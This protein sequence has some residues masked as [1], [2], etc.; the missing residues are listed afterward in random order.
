MVDLTDFLQQAAASPRGQA[1]GGWTRGKLVAP[2]E[3]LIATREARRLRLAIGDGI[4]QDGENFVAGRYGFPWLQAASGAATTKET[5]AALGLTLAILPLVEISSDALA[6]S[7]NLI[8]PDKEGDLPDFPDLMALIREC[9]LVHGVDEEAMRR[10]YEQASRERV[11]VRRQLI[12]F[13]EPAVPGRDAVIRTEI[14]LGAI[15]GKMLDDGRIDFRERRI[16]VAVKKDEIL[17]VKIPATVGRRGV[18]VRGQEIPTRDGVDIAVKT[19]DLCVFNP[20]DGTIRATGAGILSAVGDNTFRVSPKQ[21]IPGDVDFSTG[22][23][24]FQG[25]VEITGS[26]RPGFIVASRG[27]IK[28]GGGVQSATVNSRGNLVIA[29]GVV[30]EASNIRAEGDIEVKFIERGKAA[31]G[32]SL[33][34]TGSAYYSDIAAGKNIIGEAGS[35]VIGGDVRCGG[36]MTVESAGSAT[37]AD[38]VLAAGLHLRRWRRALD[39]R[40]RIDE[41]RRAIDKLIQHRGEKNIECEAYTE[42]QAELSDQRRE[43]AGLNLANGGPDELIGAADDSRTSA[44]IRVLG[45]LHAGVSVRLGNVEMV[46]DHDYAA[47]RFFQDSKGCLAVEPL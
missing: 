27:D 38:T 5:E 28:I 25:N 24:R 35:R 26:V 44:E 15:P 11:P 39:I 31:C 13:A 22:N 17:A 32:G 34:F 9:G 6:A 19:S 33:H 30:G 36:S 37:T 47:S 4:G 16:F 29:G 45:V 12:A 23:I 40:A 14:E 20:D 8:P 3:R 41:L 43:L 21:D 18:N 1:T 42:I 2:G 7:L 10:C 46:A